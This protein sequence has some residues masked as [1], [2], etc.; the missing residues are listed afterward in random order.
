MRIEE[1]ENPRDLPSKNTTGNAD[2]LLTKAIVS[3]LAE[4]FLMLSDSEVLRNNGLDETA[5]LTGSSH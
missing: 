2:G 4:P 3:N 5:S 1:L